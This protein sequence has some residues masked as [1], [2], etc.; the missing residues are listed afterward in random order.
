MSTENHL[1]QDSAEEAEGTPWP[2]EFERLLR[3]HCRF[4]AATD[5]IE[6]DAPMVALG[7]DSLATLVMILEIEATFSVAFPDAMLAG[8]Q[9][10]ARGLWSL[11]SRL[12]AE[13]RSDPR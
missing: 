7:L 12:T 1:R 3:R 2:V 13:Q 10:S 6:P 5:P 9:D 4:V 11:V 8:E